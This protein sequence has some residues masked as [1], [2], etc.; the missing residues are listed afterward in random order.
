[1]SLKPTIP[2]VNYHLLAPCNM[3]CKFCFAPFQDVIEEMKLP[4]GHLTEK[5]SL[6]LIQKLAEAGFEKLNFAGGEPT[7]TPWLPNLIAAAK[8]LG[9][10]TAI[11]TN[12]SKITEPWLD[13][14]N[15]TL[16]W[17]AISIDTV[18]PEKL[19][20]TGRAIR[21][22]VPM[23][24]EQYLEAAAAIRHR[25]I[26]LKINTVVNSVNWD[27]DLTGF[28]RAAQPERWKLFQ[29]LPVGGQNDAHIAD[30]E[31]TSEQFEAY[32]RRNSTVE[33]EAD[34]ITVVPEDNEA[35]T[36]SY[37]M[38]DPAGRFY[39]NAQGFHRYSSPILDIGVSA[40]LEQVSIDAERFDRRDGNYD[41]RRSKKAGLLQLKR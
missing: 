3:R 18:D 29:A 26:R 31:I 20:L 1:M 27:E 17:I 23:T 7:L 35:M 8:A 11:V 14:L 38:I 33:V 15:D 12:G 30:F 37:A 24:A 21:G 16:D 4:K 10:T 39:D 22:K 5:D 2:S 32:V 13:S 6:A 28:I 19:L 41:F 36:E 9:M 40:A 25:G 34:G